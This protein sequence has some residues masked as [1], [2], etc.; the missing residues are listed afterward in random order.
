MSC[1]RPL[2]LSLL[3]LFNLNRFLD[4]VLPLTL[5]ERVLFERVGLTTATYQA[6]LGVERSIASSP[7]ELLM[8]VF[9]GMMG[10]MCCWTEEKQ[11]QGEIGKGLL[12]CMAWRLA[13]PIVRPFCPPLCRP[14]FSSLSLILLFRL[15]LFSSFSDPIFPF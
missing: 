2:S 7:E 1:N 15:S 3:C 12:G 14:S 8:Y 5:E 11:S 10:T 6:E 13:V 9:V 4:G